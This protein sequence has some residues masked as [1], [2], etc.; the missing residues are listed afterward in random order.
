MTTS[1]NVGLMVV[2]HTCPD[3]GASISHA[4]ECPWNTE[5]VRATHQ[6]DAL[7]AFV[8]AFSAWA[9]KAGREQ[10]RCASLLRRGRL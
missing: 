1:D 8:Y 2:M 10:A 3:C 9:I 6:G 4:G 5:H 7:D